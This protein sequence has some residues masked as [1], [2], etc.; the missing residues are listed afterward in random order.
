MNKMKLD[1]AIINGNLT[2]VANPTYTDS[3]DESADD[4]DSESDEE[5]DVD[6]TDARFKEAIRSAN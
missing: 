1:R 3:N 5:S 4:S 6:D 2:R